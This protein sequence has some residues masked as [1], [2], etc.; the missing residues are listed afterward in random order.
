MLMYRTHL[1]C[2]HFAQLEKYRNKVFFFKQKMFIQSQNEMILNHKPL[3]RV[4]LGSFFDD[5]PVLSVEQ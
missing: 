2:D 5:Y 4:E 1:S 3:S